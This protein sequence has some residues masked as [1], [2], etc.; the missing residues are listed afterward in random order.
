M[1]INDKQDKIEKKRT[2][3][4]DERINKLYNDEFKKKD[5]MKE[6]AK[7]HEIIENTEMDCLIYS[8]RLILAKFHQQYHQEVTY[9]D[10][11]SENGPITKLSLMQFCKIII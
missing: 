9:L 1:K 8:N 3:E 2:E 10:K 7:K 4:T 11:N 6:L 5:K